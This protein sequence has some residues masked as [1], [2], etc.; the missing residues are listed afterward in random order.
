MFNLTLTLTKEGGGTGDI[1]SKQ[2][3][4]QQRLLFIQAQ[5]KEIDQD[6]LCSIS[7]SPSLKREEGQALS[8]ANNII[9]SRGCYL[10]KLSVRRSIKTDYVQSH[11]HPH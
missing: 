1:S 4:Q 11:S 10:F 8:Q 3:Y 5:C 2:H 7:L 9:S 6:R